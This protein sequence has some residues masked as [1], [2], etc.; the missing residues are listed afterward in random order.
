[1][2]LHIEMAG[3]E[4][5][6]QIFDKLEEQKAQIEACIQGEWSWRR[7]PSYGFS[8]INIRTDGSIDD[9]EAKRE[10]TRA[11]MLDLLP[12]LKEVFDPRLAEILG[13]PSE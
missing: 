6:K 7:H 2:T 3:R 5:T 12:K 11:W 8:S 13:E 4:Q 9:P 1:M 10:A